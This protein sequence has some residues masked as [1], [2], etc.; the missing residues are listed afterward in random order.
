MAPIVIFLFSFFSKEAGSDPHLKLLDSLQ[1]LIRKEVGAGTNHF[2]AQ[3]M[4]YDSIAQ[5][6]GDTLRMGK[7]KTS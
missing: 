6:S 1:T 5:L 3:A 4:A 7:G 2:L